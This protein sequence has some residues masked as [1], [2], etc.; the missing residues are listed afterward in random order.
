M[1][2]FA[3]YQTDQSANFSPYH[4]PDPL[5]DFLEDDAQ[6]GTS[7]F[8]IV[9]IIHAALYFALTSNFIVPDLKPDEPEIVPVQIVTFETPQPEPERPVEA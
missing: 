2:A 5:A 3:A 9:L 7:T 6:R 8:L 1:T 4:D